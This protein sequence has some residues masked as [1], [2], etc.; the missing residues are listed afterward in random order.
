[1]NTALFSHTFRSVLI[2]FAERGLVLQ[3]KPNLKLFKQLFWLILI[4]YCCVGMMMAPLFSILSGR[5][6]EVFSAKVCILSPLPSLSPF[7][8][9]PKKIVTQ[10][11]VPLII[12]L[13]NLAYGQYLDYKVRRYF[14]P[15]Q[16]MFSF[17]NYKRNFIT[18]E[19]NGKY[20]QINFWYTLLTNLVLN[21]FFLN[22][23][24][25]S[26][27]PQKLS[28]VQ[29]FW[30]FLYLD[31]FHGLYLPTKMTIHRKGKNVTKSFWQREHLPQPRRDEQMFELF[32][33]PASKSTAR[34]VSPFVQE[35]METTFSQGEA[36]SV[37]SCVKTRAKSTVKTSAKSRVK[38]SHSLVNTSH[39][40]SLDLVAVEIH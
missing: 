3:G 26:L 39:K 36:M 38:T 4:P 35:E 27:N 33:N 22:G 18:F 34:H 23:E 7:D 20:I 9:D 10:H 24:M 37:K 31:I 17:G 6:T 30:N 2:R 12:P 13:L 29:N 19:E 16:K 14:R 25:F 15:N 40:I 32:L 21:I 1:M 5:F 11:I 8:Q 28:W